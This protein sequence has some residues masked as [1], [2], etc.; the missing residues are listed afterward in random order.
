MTAL[1]LDFNDVDHYIKSRSHVMFYVTSS[2][3]QAGLLTTGFP[4]F[5]II[6]ISVPDYMAAVTDVYTMLV[7]LYRR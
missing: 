1:W 6:E 4:L 2:A 7:T 5:C 3:S